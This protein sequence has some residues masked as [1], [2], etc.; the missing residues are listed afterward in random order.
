MRKELNSEFLRISNLSLP[1]FPLM[2]L[3]NTFLYVIL[4][5]TPLH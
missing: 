5:I 4:A 3:L 2:V 1:D